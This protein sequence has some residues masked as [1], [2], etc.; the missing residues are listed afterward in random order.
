MRA[1]EPAWWQSVVALKRE[2]ERKSRGGDGLEPS[3]GGATSL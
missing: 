3:G 2:K 1:G